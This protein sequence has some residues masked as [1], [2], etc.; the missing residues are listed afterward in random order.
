MP[1]VV[2]RLGPEDAAVAARLFVLMA[3]TFDEPRAPV[4]HD[5]IARLLAS[6]AVWVIAAF[7][8]DEVVGGL[9]AHALPMTRAETTELFVYDVA[10][11]PAHQRMGI[12]RALFKA[13][14]VLAGTAG[15][16]GTFVAA[17]NEDSHALDFYRAIGGSPGPVTIFTFE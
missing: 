3:E 12:G 8:G 17:D 11:H 4:S 5:Y 10:V 9:T 14:R 13:L 16:E 15:I 1:I 6:E 7:S 2:R